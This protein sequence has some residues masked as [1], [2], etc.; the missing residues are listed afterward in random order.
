MGQ[1]LSTNRPQEPNMY[2]LAR[3]LALSLLSVA[4]AAIAV[5]AHADRGGHGYR[6]GYGPSHGHHG[7][8][9]HQGYRHGHAHH[10]GRSGIWG[11]LI[12]GGL[13]GATIVGSTSA[14]AHAAQPVVV[15][16]VPPVPSHL[17]AA[18]AVPP[19]VIAPAQAAPPRVQYFCAPYRAY[20]PFVA[21]C[22]EPW[23]VMPY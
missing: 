21:N 9:G 3:T 6:V 20:Y 4:A 5:P 12:V 7:H 22:P 16:V 23:Y 17:V 15:P 13:I 10:H 14:H 8:H 1:A 2:P 18:P 19:V 11:P